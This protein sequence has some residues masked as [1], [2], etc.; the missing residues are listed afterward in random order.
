MPL[1]TKST[2]PRSLEEK[3]WKVLLQRIRT[4]R[5]IPFLGAGACHGT[6][7]LGGD[8]ASQWAR[9][10]DYPLDDKNDLARVSQ[11]LAVE[12]DPYW[13]K[14]DIVEQL[15]RT[16]PPNFTLP[17]EPHALLAELPLPVYMTTNYDNF[18]VQALARAN[19]APKT[20]YCR[21]N[22]FLQGQPS[23][24]D[25]GF[26]PNVANPLVY[27]LHGAMP[28]VESMVLT[29]DDYLD[30][31]VNLAHENSMIPHQLQKALAESSLL[32][33]GYKLVDWDFRV[34]FRSLI[35]YMERSL[36]KV[37]MSVQLVPVGDVASEEQKFHALSYLDKYFGKSDVKVY[38][39]TCREFSLELRDRTG[40]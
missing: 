2:A 20:E 26:D 16:Q 37:H 25:N 13:P 14:L 6:L 9:D 24:F 10:N 39:G 3:D 11:F 12:Y 5:C 1:D 4:G 21:W 38:W 27:H 8:I 22:R 17:D 19:R 7:P 34:L 36:S 23:I 30:F 31:L 18:M 15:S 28:V 40:R 32:F 29:E 35:T 33:L